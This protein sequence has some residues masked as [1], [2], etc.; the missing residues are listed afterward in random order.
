V[1]QFRAC[2]C[3]PALPR[4]PDAESCLNQQ[5][6]Y[7]STHEAHAGFKAEVCK[8]RGNAQNECPGWGSET[9]VVKGCIQQ[10]FDE[11]VPPDDPC[12]GDCYQKHGHF[13]NMTSTKY[14]S[15]ACGKFTTSKGEVWSVQNFF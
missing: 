11:G 3:L 2:V 8:P 10:M 6:E 1:N 9:Q 7:D 4:N 15:V 5:S 12:E 13:I 14:K